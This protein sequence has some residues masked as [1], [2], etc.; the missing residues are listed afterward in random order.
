MCQSQRLG[1]DLLGKVLLD[2][3]LLFFPLLRILCMRLIYYDTMAQLSALVWPSS[4]LI[5][6]IYTNTQ[7]TTWKE[8]NVSACIPGLMLSIKKKY[9]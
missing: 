7:N 3:V 1:L 4:R 5:K 8:K 9:V 2:S 6:Y